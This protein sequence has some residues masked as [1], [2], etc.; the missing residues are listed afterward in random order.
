MIG[1]TVGSIGLNSFMCENGKFGETYDIE[2]K[3]GYISTNRFLM[4]ES[5]TTE[6]FNCAYYTTNSI[7]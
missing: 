6:E 3:S 5:K 2:C 7:D 1:T 4:G